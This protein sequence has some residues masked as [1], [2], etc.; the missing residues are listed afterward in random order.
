MADELD[1]SENQTNEPTEDQT[2][3]VHKLVDYNRLVQY[4]ALIKNYFND[5]LKYGTE[6][7]IRDWF[8]D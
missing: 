7:D 1:P 8:N 3:E 4:D 5:Q 6:A 2:V